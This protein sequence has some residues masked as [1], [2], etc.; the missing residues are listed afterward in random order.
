M[1]ISG[2]PLS[3]PLPVRGLLRAGLE[4]RP[5]DHAVITHGARL[6]WRELEDSSTRLAANLIGLGLKPGDRVASLMPDRV[7][8]VLH[9][10]ACIKAGL[11]ATPLIEELIAS[12]P[13]DVKLGPSDGLRCR[14]LG[15]LKSLCW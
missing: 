8:L 3:E 11:V 12:T 14:V 15:D 4:T 13:R 7:E 2:A 5:E 10:L 1:S 6:T 9:Y